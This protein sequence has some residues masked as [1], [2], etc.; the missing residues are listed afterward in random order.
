MRNYELLDL[1]EQKMTDIIQLN[2]RGVV[3]FKCDDLDV[4]QKCFSSA[5]AEARDALVASDAAASLAQHCYLDDIL[6]DSTKNHSFQREDCDEGMDAYGEPVLLNS[7]NFTCKSALASIFFNRGLCYARC[8]MDTEAYHLFQTSLS[9]LQSCEIQRYDGAFRLL[10]NIGRLE[11]RTGRYIHA[12]NTFTKALGISRATV[13]KGNNQ[14]L[15]EAAACNCLGVIYFHLTKPDTEKAL[16]YC[17]RSLELYNAVFGK[18]ACCKEV[19]TVR[20]HVS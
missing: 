20:L 6:D 1:S 7:S 2:N 9:V 19:A 16:S 4:A 14:K 18:K 17:S 13:S 8:F 12:I 11:H 10:F 3:A 15:E 5:A